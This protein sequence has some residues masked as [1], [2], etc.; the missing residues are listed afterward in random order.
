VGSRFGRTS[1]L[2]ASSPARWRSARGN[3][4][5]WLPVP[6]GA[7][8]HLLADRAGA[9]D[10]PGGDQHRRRTGALQAGIHPYLRTG[11]GA[12]ND[13]SLQ[14]PAASVLA[15]T[16][17]RLIP[18]DLHSVTELTSQ[19]DFR[20]QRIIAGTFLDHAFTD[21]SADPD[22]MFTACL[23]DGAGTGVIIRWGEACRWLQV[24]TADR[25]DPKTNRIGLAVEP[26]TCPPDAFNSG[27][28]ARAPELP[29]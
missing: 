2:S 17:D 8:R 6:A 27:L 3:S 1:R 11:P 21:F 28:R 4:S 7:G 15:V 22:D 9:D 26:M 23:T 5:N 29:V 16:P 18:L 19:F 12:V 10:Q 25:P 24:H 20:C 14:L 13:W